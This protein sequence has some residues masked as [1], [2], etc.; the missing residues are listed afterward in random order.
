MQ[1]G[2]KNFNQNNFDPNSLANQTAMA[3][4]FCVVSDNSVS[5][6]SYVNDMNMVAREV[7]MQEL[8]NSHRKNEIMVKNIEFGETVTH[9]SGFMPILNLPDD[10]L[11][12]NA[13]GTSTSLYQAVLEALEH[14]IRYRK[15]LED[16]GIEVRVN[17]FISTDGEDN[18]SRSDV[19]AKV[20]ALVDSL[21][22]NEAWAASF[23]IIV[24]G[25]GTA[26]NFEHACREMGLDPDK[27]LVRASESGPEIRKHMG[28]VSQS[29]SSSG[30]TSTVQF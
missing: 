15:E 23:T 9:K 6:R 11:D 14:T 5:V 19:P 21:R 10:Y 7:F 3:I 8:K 13:V 27:C 18:N 2:Y 30:K 4:L 17:I 25:V 16:Q 1:E 26:A 28:V 24:L 20:R 29:V 22:S 12:I